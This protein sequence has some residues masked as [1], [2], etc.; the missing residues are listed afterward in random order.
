V[1]EEDTVAAD[2]TEPAGGTGTGTGTGTEPSYE[3]AITELERIVTDLQNDEVGVDELAAKVARG[4]RLVELCRERLR[5]A[6]LAVDEVV[7]ALRT[8]GEQEPTGEGESTGS[9]RPSSDQRPEPD[10]DALF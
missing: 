2:A 5:R 8:A 9:V 10:D 7:D 3:A 1:S 4:A 6:E